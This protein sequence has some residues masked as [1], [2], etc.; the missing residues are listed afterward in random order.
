MWLAANQNRLND[1]NVYPVPDGDTGHKHGSHDD[2]YLTGIAWQFQGFKHRNSCYR[3]QTIEKH[4][5]RMNSPQFAIAHVESRKTAEWYAE[6]IGSRYPQSEI[7][8]TAASPVLGAHAGPGAAA[9]AILD[10]S[11]GTA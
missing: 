11:P 9:V 6:R 2:V 8:T 1:I 10:H 4:A 5:Q 3:F 7:L